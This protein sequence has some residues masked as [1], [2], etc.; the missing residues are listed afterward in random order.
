ML[1]RLSEREYTF[2]CFLSH[3]DA[4]RPKRALVKGMEAI[5]SGRRVKAYRAGELAWRKLDIPPIED[6]YRNTLPT[7]ANLASQHKFVELI[8]IAE[9]TDL[10]VRSRSQYLAHRVLIGV[11]GI[12]GWRS[13]CKSF[14]GHSSSCSGLSNY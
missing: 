2:A 12:G 7:L 10:N 5:V 11:T 9:Q 13:P 4:S 14:A 3:V 6:V 8:R 1:I